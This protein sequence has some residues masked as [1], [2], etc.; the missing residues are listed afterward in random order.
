M[1]KIK[2]YSILAEKSSTLNMILPDSTD[3]EKEP[4]VNG[5]SKIDKKQVLKTN[6]SL[7][8]VESI[9]ECCNTFDVH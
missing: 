6:G 4:T 7:M 2:P 1:K 8:K 9:A 3:T 5:H